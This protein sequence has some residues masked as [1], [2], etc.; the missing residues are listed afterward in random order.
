MLTS[1]KWV[2]LIGCPGSYAANSIGI[3]QKA[4]IIVNVKGM[5]GTD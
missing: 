4:N 5:L 1:T 2:G 3:L